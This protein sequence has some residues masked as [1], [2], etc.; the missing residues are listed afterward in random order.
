MPSLPPIPVV[1]SVP[2]ASSVGAISP[3]ASKRVGVVGIVVS[4]AEV[5]VLMAGAVKSAA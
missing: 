4:I 2:V 3:R 1:S 5:A